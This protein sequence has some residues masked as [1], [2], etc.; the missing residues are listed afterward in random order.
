[1]LTLPERKRW[2]VTA[3]ESLSHKFETI[4]SQLITPMSRN[5]CGTLLTS[6]TLEQNVQKFSLQRITA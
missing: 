5:C 2:H 4:V 6:N 1:M 3:V